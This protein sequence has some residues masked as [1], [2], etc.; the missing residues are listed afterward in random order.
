MNMKRKKFI[1]ILLVLLY[2]CG[3]A[4]IIAVAYVGSVLGTWSDNNGGHE[5][6][7]DQTD[8]PGPAA[9]R[10]ITDGFAFFFNDP[11]DEW[12]LIG[13][14][15]NRDME[16]L[17]THPT[18]GTVSYDGAYID[19]ET[20]QL[21]SS[22]S[23]APVGNLLL[24]KPFEHGDELTGLWDVEDDPGH[25]YEFGFDRSVEERRSGAVVNTYQVNSDSGLVVQ[26]ERVGDGEII[27]GDVQDAVTLTLR[28]G[29]TLIRRG[30]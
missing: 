13:S 25:E 1:P 7:F 16:L 23:N 11:N 17:L 21:S 9:Q 14:I 8:P 27:L 24:K 22:D 3:G 10:T 2:A 19:V 12:D 29:E 4:G 26:M 15:D 5:L 30:P 28:T 20:L 18:L 6:H